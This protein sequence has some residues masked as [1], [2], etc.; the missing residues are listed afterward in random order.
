MMSLVRAQYQ[1]DSD[2]RHQGLELHPSLTAHAQDTQHPHQV[3]F[4]GPS[5]CLHIYVLYSVHTHMQEEKKYIFH[6]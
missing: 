4:F 1:D 3:G 2:E 6:P 5:G